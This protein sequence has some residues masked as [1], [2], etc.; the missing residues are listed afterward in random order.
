MEKQNAE[1]KLSCE[2]E[3]SK[4]KKE[5]LTLKHQVGGYKTRISTLLQ[6]IAEGSELRSILQ[7]EINNAKL[8]SKGLEDQV[9]TLNMD[10]SKC[11]ALYAK[12]KDDFETYK[13]KYESVMALPWYR[14]IFL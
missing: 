9:K 3:L 2:E 12:A 4:L 14:R 1:R 7:D 8:V 5:N 11:Q 13:Q 10:L 6:E